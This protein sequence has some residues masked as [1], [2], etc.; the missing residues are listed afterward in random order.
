[1]KYKVKVITSDKRLRP[2][3]PV[4]F[5]FDNEEAWRKFLPSPLGKKD[6]Q[7]TATWLKEGEE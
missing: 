2:R 4:F 1:M 3:K 5:S 7:Q 6:R